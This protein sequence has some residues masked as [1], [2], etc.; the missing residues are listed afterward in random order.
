TAS[1][2][3][4]PG[5]SVRLKLT[6]SY[7]GLLMLAGALLLAAVW[8]VLLRYGPPGA[9]PLPDGQELP[10]GVGAPPG[11]LDRVAIYT[12]GAL[13]PNRVVIRGDA[14]VAL[15]ILFGAFAPAAAVVLAFLLVFGLLGG[16]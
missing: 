6:L 13:A 8:V 7:A 4:A 12:A 9:P 11:L 10:P 3:R 2:D 14:L 1:L 15:R 5:F 16:W